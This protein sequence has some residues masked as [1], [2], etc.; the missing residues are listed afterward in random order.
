M[1]LTGSDKHSSLFFSV[2]N[3]LKWR[4]LGRVRGGYSQTFYCNLRMGPIRLRV[5]PWLA[6]Q[7]RRKKVLRTGSHHYNESILHPRLCSPPDLRL[8][9]QALIRLGR[10]NNKNIFEQIVASLPIGWQHSYSSKSYHFFNMFFVPMPM[11]GFES[12][13]LW[14]DCSTIALPGYNS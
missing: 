12:L 10:Y 1:E 13:G 11:E 8:L 14:L 9:L 4:L 5:C 7:L 6:F 2:L 3:I